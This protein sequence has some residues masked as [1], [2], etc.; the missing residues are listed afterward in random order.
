MTCALVS[1][2]RAVVTD[3]PSGPCFLLGSLPPKT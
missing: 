1:V 3:L 2:L